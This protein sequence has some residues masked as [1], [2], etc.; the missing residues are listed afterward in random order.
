MSIAGGMVG[1]GTTAPAY[2]LDV[3]RAVG[4]TSAK[5]GSSDALYT[6]FS[7]PGL[8]FNAYVNN[9]WRYGK[10]ST[11]HYGGAV[12]L[13]PG[14]GDFIFQAS[15]A[16]GNADAAYTSVERLRIRQGGG[17][18][19]AGGQ[20][21][22]DNAEA[23]AGR[24]R[25]GAAWN[26]PGIYGE[27]ATKAL[28]LGSASNW[29]YVNGSL[30]IGHNQ[31]AEP[32]H[33]TQPAQDKGIRLLRN[34]G[35][36]WWGISVW[37]DNDL[38]FRTGAHSPY[39][40]Y[41]RD[42]DGTYNVASDRRLK[43]DVEYQDRVVVS[44]SVENDSTA[45]PVSGTQ[46]TLYRNGY[47][48]ATLPATQR[49]YQDL[50][51]FPGETYEYAATVSNDLGE[52]QQVVDTGFLNPNGV[53]TG[54]VRTPNGNAVQDVKVVLTPNLGRSALFDGTA[55]A[56]FPTMISGLSGDYTLEGWFRSR[57][58]QQQTLFAAVDSATTSYVL[59]LELTEQGQVRWQH[60][61]VPGQAG[62]AITTVMGYTQDG[63][64][65]HFAAVFDSTAPAA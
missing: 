48:L 57:E 11:S 7:W 59:L 5:L 46:I 29:V 62:T 15:S 65:H 28:V 23:D 1:I 16:P 13:D 18:S 33:I 2:G 8:A 17:L 36:S 34:N 49:A 12:T 10:G 52:S 55:Y 50:N 14:S 42:T 43:Q 37:D 47:V 39:R 4:Q 27:N 20:V 21:Y 54:A 30:G 40:A 25:V 32:L 63:E 31:P 60:A 64:W 6:L 44:W 19:I 45:A 56:Y 53:I 35:A 38:V 51:V 61:A 24:L 3:E 58:A 9:G 41:I 26:Y 22:V